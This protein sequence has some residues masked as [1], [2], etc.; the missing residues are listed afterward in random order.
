MH[1]EL[2]HTVDYIWENHQRKTI[3]DADHHAVHR[4]LELLTA[5]ELRAAVRGNDG[6]WR[7]VEWVK[8]AVL[9]HF[10]L[11]PSRPL[12]AGALHFYDKVPLQDGWGEKGVRVVPPG[13]VRHGAHICRGVV[14][15]PCFVNIGAWVGAGT[16]VDTWATV[17]SCAQIGERCH[18]SGGAGIGGVM[19]PIQATPV[20]IEDDVFIG[21]RAEVAEGCVVRKGAVLAMGCFLSASTK[22]MDVTKGNAISHGEIPEG[23]V[24]V[25]GSI[26]A[27]DGTHSTYALIIKKYRDESTD[28]RTALNS[29]LR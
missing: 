5:G 12:E 13:A 26:P 7:A 8:R 24:V 9:L 18:I 25:P 22:V 1:E 29:L 17:G 23:A 3:T 2:R 15:M 20:I 6:T 27:A 28:A 10:R 16:M 11:T 4:A 19:E 14:L 21:A